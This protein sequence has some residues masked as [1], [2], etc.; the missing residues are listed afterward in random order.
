MVAPEPGEPLLLYITTTSKV[1]SMVLVVERLEPQQP[2]A[3]KGAPAVRSGSKDPDP[4]EGSCD[5][6]ASGSQL[7]EP[8]LS[9]EPQIGSQLPEVPSGLEDQEA[10]GSQI[11]EPTL[12]LDNQHTTESQLPE[13]P[14][15]AGG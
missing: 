11:S 4:V 5:E 2:Q 1:M 6:E 13:V 15:G 9:L 12:G 10:S 3:L 7:P 14:S 8:T